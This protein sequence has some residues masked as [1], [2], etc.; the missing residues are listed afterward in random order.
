MCVKY[1]ADCW[2]VQVKCRVVA[3]RFQAQALMDMALACGS[4]FPRIDSRDFLASIVLE[5]DKILQLHT[6]RLGSASVVAY[7]NDRHWRILIE[8]ANSFHLR[9]AGGKANAGNLP[10]LEDYLKEFQTL[11]SKRGITAVV[12]LVDDVFRALSGVDRPTTQCDFL[13]PVLSDLD[14]FN[15]RWLRVF[16]FAS[17]ECETALRDQHWYPDSI[18]R[19][20]LGWTAPAIID[21]L[22]LRLRAFRV[23]RGKGPTDLDELCEE[24]VKSKIPTQLAYA[25]ELHPLNALRLARLLIEKHCEREAEPRLISR[26]TWDIVKHEWETQLKPEL[27]RAANDYYRCGP[28]ATP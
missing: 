18:E 28:G 5:V 25:A 16:V 26:A 22:N 10:S 8:R 15:S 11:L 7:W 17:R 3:I 23:Q 27:N 19:E 1:A 6:A 20:Y 21:M 14:I 13:R 12:V 4:R 2:P 24:P 9:S